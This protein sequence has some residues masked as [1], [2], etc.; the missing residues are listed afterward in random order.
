MRYEVKLDGFEGKKVEVEVK[1]I[2]NP[3]L[4]IDN[5]PVAV[6]KKRKMKLIKNDGTEVIAN[7]KHSFFSV[8]P[9]PKLVV[10]G[11]EFQVTEPL[12]W[13]VKVWCGLP[14]LLV[15]WGGALG[16]L[17]GVIGISINSKIFRSSLNTILKFLISLVVSS[18]AVII[19]IF[20]ASFLHAALA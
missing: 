4:L 2:G 3:R 15:L 11:K 16:A 6:E 20:I 1:G 19:F 12:K 5:E 13:Y 18:L 7:W 10:D 17:C 14:L 8:D 9:I